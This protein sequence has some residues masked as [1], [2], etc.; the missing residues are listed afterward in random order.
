MTRLRNLAASA[1]P[2][3]E[4]LKENEHQRQLAQAQNPW[5]LKPHIE[6]SES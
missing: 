5:P 6:S 2:L 1:R 4:V 3:A